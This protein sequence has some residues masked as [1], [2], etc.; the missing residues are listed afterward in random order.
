MK[1]VG[2]NTLFAVIFKQSEIDLA[3]FR[4]FL[5]TKKLKEYTSYRQGSS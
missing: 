2:L 5:I 3:N 4:G 1:E